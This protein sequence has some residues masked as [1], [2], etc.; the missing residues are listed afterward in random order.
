M[1]KDII[2]IPQLFCLEPLT[3]VP[4]N[5]QTLKPFARPY[6][7]NMVRAMGRAWFKHVCWCWMGVA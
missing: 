6:F 3:N 4:S 1:D 5:Q 2:A 7:P